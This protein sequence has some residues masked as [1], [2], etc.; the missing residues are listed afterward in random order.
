VCGLCTVSG[1]G[2][3]G[4]GGTEPRFVAGSVDVIPA[5]ARVE[6]DRD[7]SVFVFDRRTQ[8]AVRRG[9]PEAAGA[10]DLL[11]ELLRGAFADR[12]GPVAVGDGPQPAGSV[13]LTTAAADPLLGRDGYALEVTSD[14]VTL[15]A[16]A[17]AGF[18]HGVQTLRQLLPPEIESSAPPVGV[19]WSVPSV[20]IRDVPRFGWR[21]L[22]IDTSRFFIPKDLL[23]RELELMALYKL[24]VLHLHLTDDQGW[25][26]EIDA[27]PSLH[28]LG[29]QWDAERAPGE[30]GGYY[31]KDDIREIVARAAALGIDVLPEIDM[32][33]HIVA[34]LHA[35]PE[36]ACRTAP[37]VPRT[38]DEFPIVPVLSRQFPP[39]ILCV[40]DEGVY[41]VIASVLDEVVDLFP[42]PFVHVGGDEVVHTDE[43]AAGYLCQGLIE[44]GAVAGVDR[45]QAYFETR[46]EGLLRARGRRLIAWDEAL[47][48]EDPDT[49]SERLSSDAAFMYWRDF[50]PPAPRLYDRD[51]VA[52]PFTR[53]YL[54]YPTPIDQIYQFEPEPA[55]LTAEQRAHLLGAE[56]AIW[57]GYPNARSDDGFEKHIFPRLLAIA[58]LG[59]TPREHRDLDDFHRRLALHQRRLEILGVRQGP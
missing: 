3:G 6:I 56:G 39:N 16:L 54:D 11:V 20:R 37:D 48:S 13:L 53:L 21:G 4:S 59:W 31:T 23:V 2:D 29:S 51:W 15:R 41:D 50:M 55:G 32:P 7:G 33:G 25:R 49:P 44:Q 18:A 35:L 9:E 58:E 43:W 17:P 36:L 26:L 28:Q 57:T 14:R 5:P 8:V 12:D 24:S 38:A 45:L 1:C 47:V 46:V 30:R 22:L 42:G 10:A 40:C 34:A 27:Y 52:T 19:V